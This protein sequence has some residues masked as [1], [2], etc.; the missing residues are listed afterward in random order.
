MTAFIQPPDVSVDHP[1]LQPQVQQLIFP[2]MDILEGVDIPLADGWADKQPQAYSDVL[3]AI[4]NALKVWS[5]NGWKILN[6]IHDKTAVQANAL[7]AEFYNSE[8]RMV[9]RFNALSQKIALAFIPM[10]VSIYKEHGNFL[11]TLTLARDAQGYPLLHGDDIVIMA[12]YIK[13]Y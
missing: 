1:W 9:D 2:L 8:Y 12:T 6:E 4:E 5:K 3:N 11:D 10:M 13:A 7:V